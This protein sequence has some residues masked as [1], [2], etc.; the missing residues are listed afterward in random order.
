M[1]AGIFSSLSEVPG[2]TTH[3]KPW[4][5]RHKVRVGDTGRFVTQ[6]G[7][8]KECGLFPFRIEKILH[9]EERFQPAVRQFHGKLVSLRKVE[10]GPGGRFCTAV[11]D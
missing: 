1:L 7:V 3:H 2:E 8:K 10:R 9:E 11:F 4:I 5:P 6:A